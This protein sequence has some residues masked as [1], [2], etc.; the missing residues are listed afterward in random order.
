M[1]SLLVPLA[2]GSMAIVG[3][4][5]LGQ[6]VRL[7]GL[8]TRSLGRGVGALNLGAGLTL[9]GYVL[10]LALA[11]RE[12]M[13]LAARI[14]YVGLVTVPVAWVA[15]AAVLSGREGWSGRRMLAL[16]S[17]PP[18]LVLASVW[19]GYPEGWIWREIRPGTVAGMSVL[20]PTY[21][22]GFWL[23]LIYSY[24]LVALG[25]LWIG[26][27][28]ARSHGALRRESRCFL[29]AI[30]MPAV[31]N[32]VYL[33]RVASL[34]L[35]LTPLA[36]GFS[37]LLLVRVLRLG[38]V[39]ELVTHARSMVFDILRCGVL[40]E[41]FDG[42]ILD[43]NSAA[44]RLLRSP[45]R[46][47]G[48]RLAEVLPPAQASLLERLPVEA[49]GE[50]TVAGPGQGT[51]YRLESIPVT[52]ALGRREG[53][54]VLVYDVTDEQ[55]R[56]AAETEYRRLLDNLPVGVF[57]NTAG[58]DGR[59]LMANPATLRI[60]G[61]DDLET[62]LHTPVAAFYPNPEDREDFSRRLIE[63]GVVVVEEQLRR[64]DGRL[65]WA[66]VTMRAVRDAD[67]QVLYFD[68]L[69][70]DVSE[71]HEAQ[72]Q[73]RRA[74]EE[75]QVANRAKSE[76]LANMSHEIRTPMNGIMGMA[77]LLADTHLDEQQQQYVDTINS[78]ADA[79]LTLINDI[80]D[81]SKIEAGK[82]ELEEIDFDL[83]ETVEEVGDLIAVKA[84][85]K[86]LEVIVAVE[87]EV[88]E[89]VRGDPVRVRQVLINLA[90]NAVKF[91]EQGEIEIH[92]GVL[93]RAGRQV[94]L[95]F[96]VRDTGI[97]IPEGRQ[98]ALFDAF[99]QQDA[100]TTRK[101]GGTGLGLAICKQLAAMFG[102]EIGVDSK[103]GSGST[104]WFTALLG[105][106]AD[107]CA[108]ATE[109]SEVL[110]GARVLVVDDNATNRTMLE[111]RLRGWGC[112][113]ETADAAP[114]ALAMMQAAAE[115]GRAYDVAILDMQMPR[116][117]GAM[118]AQAIRTA[119]PNA[120]TKLVSMSSMSGGSA[121]AE[122]G[123]F[124]A[125]LTKPVKARLL[126]RAL[127][128][129]LERRTPAGR[130]ADRR[131][132]EGTTEVP[133]R[134]LVV[135]DNGVNR[136]LALALLA[137]MGHTAD[138]V[139]D[140]RAALAKLREKAYD[141]VLM[142]VQM[143]VMDGLEATRRIRAGEVPCPQIP[144]IALTA[145]AIKGDRE[146]CLAAGMDGYVSKPI[147]LDELRAALAAAAAGRGES[148]GD[149]PAP[150]AAAED[151]PS[152]DRRGDA[153][154]TAE[155]P[156]HSPTAF[157]EL[158]GAGRRLRVEA[159]RG[160]PPATV[161]TGAD[162]AETVRGVLEPVRNA[163]GGSSVA[164]GEFVS[165]ATECIDRILDAEA[166]DDP[167]GVERA[168][169]ELAAAARAEGASRIANLAQHA[170]DD[171][172]RGL[173]GWELA[174]RLDRLGVAIEEH[175]ADRQRGAA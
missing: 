77:G 71:R 115:A 157:S 166:A 10:E 172:A 96:D 1:E 98:E 150:V 97:G 144:V 134:V 132:S 41:D 102:G 108:D 23:H 107:R 38:R 66:E 154:P 131:P 61:A 36:F 11:S 116:V 54:M 17:A 22:P 170:A 136:Q 74:K 155:A 83:R 129:V 135:E 72:E 7:L 55:A 58:A 48:R 142:D 104:F 143:P 145:R 51:F 65:I 25:T 165:V 31:A 57:R 91:T 16:L 95:R 124:A 138:A 20:D 163:P 44:R 137:K 53:R 99:T 167:A 32:A 93:E 151:A 117:D 146:E 82:L 130:A 3:T 156:P 9:L 26:A 24:T 133:L 158:T 6:G 175:A 85:E 49:D 27:R 75:A 40:L 19:T 121:S 69:I 105:A 92:V 21:G 140:G 79:L 18:V 114:R 152:S 68:G 4:A 111:R 123:H 13:L 47:E 62:F 78:C 67:G 2:L 86:G 5:C 39:I 103:L 128:A 73:L 153:V 159:V 29:L 90:G 34:P 8:R 70:E 125:R 59:F 101:Y 52:D 164:P 147:R 30:T 161:P 63:E 162:R 169:R 118:L 106:V 94:R 148:P 76:F 122:Q 113:V 87:P 141:V 43:A 149:L 100:S 60:L 126:R 14:Q 109:G 50:V 160:A 88:P 127:T 89:L 15:I 112:R 174:D 119:L 28:V 171:A 42:R 81:F 80:L 84:Q 168:C 56:L 46:L 12:Q 64:L 33:G 120:A 35:D 37:A 173:L 110:R 45:Q 139:G